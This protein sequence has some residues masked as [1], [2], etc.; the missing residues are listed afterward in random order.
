LRHEEGKSPLC[1]AQGVDGIG[2]SDGLPRDFGVQ[3][4]NH[5]PV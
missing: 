5:S 3:K 1:R 4:L 2:Q